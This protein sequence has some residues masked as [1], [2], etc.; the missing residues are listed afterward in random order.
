MDRVVV[1]DGCPTVI[2][3]RVAVWSFGAESQP[4]THC[5]RGRPSAA[6][7]ANGRMPL[8]SVSAAPK[9]P[10]GVL[11]RAW[12]A[13]LTQVTST[14]PSSPIATSPGTASRASVWNV[15]NP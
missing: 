12:T 10:P 11:R 4:E 2:D 7:D 9:R 1:S 5:T 8:P 3:P 13:R 14:R 15:P 6:N